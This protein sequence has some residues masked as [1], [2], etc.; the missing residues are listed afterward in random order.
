MANLFKVIN[1]ELILM[2]YGKFT[3]AISWNDDGTIKDILERPAIGYSI[4]VGNELANW[5]CNELSTTEIIKIIS[6]KPNQVRFL[7]E[8]GVYE[9]RK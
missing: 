2:E 5:D 7:T 1:D 8:S 3:E 4:H 9:W 6:A